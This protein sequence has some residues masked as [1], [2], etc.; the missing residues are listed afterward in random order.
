MKRVRLIQH[1]SKTGFTLVELLV[2]MVI[3]SILT[4]VLVPM[5]QIAILKAHMTRTTA[6]GR[7]IYQ[8][9]FAERDRS[10]PLPKS[11]GAD[12]FTSSTDYWRHIVAEDSLR[13]TFDFFSADGLDSYAGLRPESFLPE[14]NAWSIVADLSWSDHPVTPLFM[15][16]NLTLD[17]LSDP[18]EGSLSG[19]S[20]YG[21]HGAIL[22]RL[23]G[24]AEIVKEADL[25][26]EFFNPNNATN[27][28]LKP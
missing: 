25:D 21:H 13:V 8:S 24:Q 17:S 9:V 16:R 6:N 18:L 26:P 10:T 2:V 12:A 1:P 15:T 5:V 28:I 3:I 20:P 27:S 14:H 19:D 11:V 4:A 7:S 22:V 23:S